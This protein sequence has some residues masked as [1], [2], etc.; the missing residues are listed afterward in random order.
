MD[1]GIQAMDGNKS[2]GQM[3]NSGNMPSRWAELAMPINRAGLKTR[4]MRL[5]PRYILHFLP[6]IRV[7]WE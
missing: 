7:K 3:L 4:M 6:I 5:L 2:V 1:A